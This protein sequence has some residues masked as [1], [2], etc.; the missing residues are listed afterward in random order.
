MATNKKSV[1]K[2]VESKYSKLI[3]AAQKAGKDTTKLE[4]QQEAE[5]LAIKKKYAD[6]EF[7][8][9]VLSVI[10]KTAESIMD[11]TAH[12]AHNPIVES[13]LIA[14]AVAEGAVQLAVA[15]NT[16]DEAAGL[17]EGG[18]SDGYTGTGNSRDVAGVIPVH[19]NEFVANHKAVGNPAVRQFLDVFDASQKDGTISMMNTTDI[20]DK[21]RITGGKYDG[22]YTGGGNT[23]GSNTQSV[24]TGSDEID[25]TNKD[26]LECLIQIMG[27]T[28]ATAEKDTVTIRDIKK[29][30]QHIDTLEKN[31]SR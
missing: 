4:E 26:L 13:I 21:V 10:A 6:K 8:M 29:K 18:Y 2:I 1:A 15:K 22:G 30:I 27:Y 23:G 24:N 19:K 7:Q 9:T 20:L 31:A 16:R 17:Y 5:K 3:K 25:V 28:K 14:G 11:I 12:W